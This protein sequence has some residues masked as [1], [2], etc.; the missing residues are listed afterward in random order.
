M[1]NSNLDMVLIKE[2]ENYLFYSEGQQVSGCPLKAYKA[3]GGSQIIAYKCAMF[4]VNKYDNDEI[5]YN[6]LLDIADIIWGYCQ[7]QYRIW[8]EVLTS[9]KLELEE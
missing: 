3:K 4:L 6:E 8:E 9:E 2:I 5:K 1:D 7:P